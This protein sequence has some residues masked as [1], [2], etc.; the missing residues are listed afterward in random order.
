MVLH[1]CRQT[2]G[3]IRRV[4]NFDRIADRERFVVVYP[5]VTSHSLMRIRNCWGW[6]LPGEIRPGAGEVEDLWQIVEQVRGE[7]CID[8]NRIHIAGLSSGGGMAV[9][10]MVA[11]ADRIASGAV[12]AGLPYSETA[13]ALPLVS[14]PVFKPVDAVVD[15]MRSVVGD[16]GRPGPIFIVHSHGDRLVDIQ[17]ARNIRDSWARCHG[18]DTSRP[19]STRAGTTRGAGWVHETYREAGTRTAVETLFI[20][21]RDH[22]WYG[23]KPGEF[24]YPDA[25]DVSALMWRFFKRHPLYGEARG[26]PRW[27]QML[28]VG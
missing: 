3:D 13:H 5:F 28:G 8:E 2:S 17:A 25:P 27:R 23:G 1:G 19:A 9:A 14:S 12:V 10:A 4:S 20:E 22:G 6:W 7:F 16:Q 24:S 26:E 11:H 18:I 15:A 21:G